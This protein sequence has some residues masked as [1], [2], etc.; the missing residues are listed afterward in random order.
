MTATSRPKKVVLPQDKDKRKDIKT[1]DQKTDDELLHKNE[2]KYEKQPT[3]Y[4]D[5]TTPA[6]ESRFNAS[7]L[8]GQD[9]HY[10]PLNDTD[11]GA[12][13]VSAGR[14]ANCYYDGATE[15]IQG[16]EDFAR[17]DFIAD[18]ARV[19]VSQKSNIG[20]LF[21]FADDTESD[22]MSAVGI[23]ADAVRVVSR[24][25]AA[26]IKLIV[27]PD[28]TGKYPS[29]NS[30]R[31]SAGPAGGV[32]LIG[33]GK[34]KVEPMVKAD[35]LADTLSV[36]VSHIQEL[37][38]TVYEFVQTQKRFNDAVAQ[39]TDVEAFYAQH[40]IPDPQVLKAMGM[41]AVELFSYVEND[42]ASISGDL[43]KFSAKHLG[44][45]KD[46]ESKDTTGV[47]K[48]ASKHHKLN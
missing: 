24:D 17:G 27:A 29:Q 20:K 13:D 1:G 35:A 37:K 46:A 45:A 38:T 28:A 10:G 21:G 26:G 14:L 44:I 4:R 23:K 16:P 40:G 32:Q 9:F 30:R 47:P 31:G 15:G 2:N 43:N 41:C 11:V 48:F 22:N 25:P 34:D 7:V 3:L 6:L 42:L 36:L 12:I 5:G 18:A 33:P 8:A 39:A 19:Y